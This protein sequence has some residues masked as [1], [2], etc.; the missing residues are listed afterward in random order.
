MLMRGKYGEAGFSPQRIRELE[1]AWRG[2]AGAGYYARVEQHGEGP[3]AL[4]V[5]RFSDGSV[6]HMTLLEL[7]SVLAVDKSEVFVDA[8]GTLHAV[9]LGTLSFAP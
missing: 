9:H 6:A 8:G 5:Y 7:R 1:G 4:A 3:P 2:V